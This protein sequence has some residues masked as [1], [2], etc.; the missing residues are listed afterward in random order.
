MV[1]I[2][3]G[4]FVLVWVISAVVKATQDPGPRRPQGGPNRPRPNGEPQPQRTSNTDIDRFMAE[5]DRLRR[6]GEGEPAGQ[7][8]ADQRP[9]PR[10]AQR[11]VETQEQPRPPRPEPR[12]RPVEER[13]RDRDR[14][15]RPRQARP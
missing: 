14:E 2:V 5:I 6:R 3:L 1:L 13:R 4:L 10:P 12:P 11:P 7:R 8:P 9:A 15:R